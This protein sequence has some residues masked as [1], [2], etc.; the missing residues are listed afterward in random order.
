MK[1][2]LL[3]AAAGWTMIALD[4]CGQQQDSTIRQP[5]AIGIRTHYGVILPHSEEIRSISFSRPRGAELE[6]SRQLLRKQYWQYCSCYPRIGISA[7]Y[8]SFDN[9]QILGNALSAI[10]FVE[11]F[12]AAPARWSVSYR[13]G[14][15]LSYL[16]RVFHP[17]DNP[18][19]LFYS[20]PISFNLLMNVSLNYRL[21]PQLTLRVH[22]NFNHISNGGLKQPNSG[23]NFPTMG[24]AVDYTPEKF[25][26]P[27]FEQTNWREEYQ[28]F[29]QYRVATY[30]TAKTA[31]RNDDRRYWI[32]GL[33]A[34]VSRRVGRLSAVGVSAETTIDYSLK[35]WLHRY[36][37]Q[38]AHQFIRAAALLG[39][40]L[41]IGRFGFAQQLGVYVYA[42]YK[43]M[44]PVYQ[45]YELT[46]KA[47]NGM[48]FGMNLKAH[49]RTADFMDLR[50]GY[51]F[52]Q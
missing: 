1:H 27:I 51:I 37:P 35:E 46:Y 43:A 34:D 6:L 7:G 44:H 5:I 47:P 14:A 49:T 2:L 33:T 41:L 13:L 52:R 28:Q 20:T 15:G 3:M 22:G 38:R 25:S 42:P 36:K 39:H 11:P 17:I 10:A 23:I 16:N 4:V 50:I 32:W 48:F 26:F 21:N 31:E 18:L 24:I 30:T 12:M 19:N 29:W 40:E 45:R 9:P 8:F